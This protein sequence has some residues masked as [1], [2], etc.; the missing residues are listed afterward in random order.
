LT[1]NSAIIDYSGPVGTLVTTVRQHLQNNRL[2]STSVAAGSTGLG[3]GDNGVLN[4]STCAGQSVDASS[5]V[6][7]FTY[8]GDSDLDGD[9]D[10]ADLGALATSWQTP[11]QWTSG[12]F[13]YNGTI[14]VNDLGMLAT[15]WQQG[16]GSPLG[17]GSLNAALSSLGL[18]TVAVPE[19][20][21]LGIHALS[22]GLLS[23]RRRTQRRRG[24]DV[25]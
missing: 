1:N 25:S 6:I 13:D 10:V 16:V 21:C 12:D 22:I 18:S 9:V 24:P 7:K 23:M 19:P 2:T 8:L 17:P 4:K 20:A 3:Y 15:N 11:G 5:L 14:D